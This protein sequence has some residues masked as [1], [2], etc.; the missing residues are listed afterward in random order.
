MTDAKPLTNE[1]LKFS[2]S[3]RLEM[4]LR[5]TEAAQCG[6]C[7]ECVRLKE[8]LGVRIR[9]VKVEPRPHREDSERI[10][11]KCPRCKENV[12]IRHICQE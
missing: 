4:P 2:Q 7:G 10:L 8:L 12:R 5:P 11:G 6:C 1:E 3:R 9:D